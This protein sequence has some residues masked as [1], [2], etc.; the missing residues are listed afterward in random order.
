MVLCVWSM[1][2]SG[3]LQWVWCCHAAGGYFFVGTLEGDILQVFDPL[4]M[5]LRLALSIS[6]LNSLRTAVGS[7]T[8]TARICQWEL[9]PRE[10]MPESEQPSICPTMAGEP[11]VR[12]RGHANAVRCMC[13]DS[14]FLFSGSLVCIK[15]LACD[16]C[17][18][19]TC[20]L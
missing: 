13:F 18:M 2:L 14:G 4:G 1:V 17:V 6:T 19:C 5:P 10:Q 11:Q 3:R 15:D 20:Y 7:C 16:L 9:T 8:D 12:Y